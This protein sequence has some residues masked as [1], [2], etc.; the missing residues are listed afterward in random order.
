MSFVLQ[1]IYQEALGATIDFMPEFV[2]GIFVFL[3]FYTAYLASGVIFNKILHRE[4]HGKRSIIRF[5]K[6]FTRVSLIVVGIITMLGT[7]GVDISAIVAGLGLTGFAL[8]FAL[9]DVLSSLLAG[10]IIMVYKPFNIGGEINVCGVE[11]KVAGIDLRYTILESHGQRHLVPNS[12]IL[13]E[14]VTILK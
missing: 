8:G 7:W 1:S 12:K 6:K 2:S 4:T 11:G 5:L 9:K 3:I 10:I 14:K 13:S